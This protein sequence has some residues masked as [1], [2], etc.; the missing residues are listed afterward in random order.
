M[1][2]RDLVTSGSSRAKFGQKLNHRIV[3]AALAFGNENGYGCR[4][5]SLGAGA[6]GEE[7][8][9][10]DRSLA[11]AAEHAETFGKHGRPVLHYS[12]RE[13]WGVPV[14]HC[15]CYINIIEAEATILFFC[16]R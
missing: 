8:V 7:S 1:R 6:D 9:P 13:A 4:G 15:F 16:H 14:L 5:K 12:N 11:H 10:V 2:V 3:P